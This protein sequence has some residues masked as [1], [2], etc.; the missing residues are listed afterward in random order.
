MGL[1]DSKANKRAFY[2]Y[3]MGLVIAVCLGYCSCAG[4]VCVNMTLIVLG[5]LTESCSAFKMRNE[6]ALNTTKG[7]GVVVFDRNMFDSTSDRSYP[8]GRKLQSREGNFL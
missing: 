2:S 3:L 5:I 1:T 7:A 6:H 8:A 4:G